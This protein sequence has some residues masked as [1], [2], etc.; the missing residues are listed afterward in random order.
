MCAMSV[1]K[2][3]EPEPPTGVY[4]RIMLS[5]LRTAVVWLLLLALPVQGVAAAT[6]LYCGPAQGAREAEAVVQRPHA[7]NAPTVAHQ[8]QPGHHDHSTH[9]HAAATA[10]EEPKAISDQGPSQPSS[11]GSLEQT[12]DG[13]C[14]VCATCCNA[15]AVSPA[16]VLPPRSDDPA[17]VHAV[18]ESQISF[19]TEGPLRPPRPFL[20]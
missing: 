20:A 14:S 6:M 3:G 16:L 15:A 18:P 7:D 12:A 5:H 19:L 13:K 8:A 1:G 4:N 11:P 2:G 10:H 9:Q 17:P